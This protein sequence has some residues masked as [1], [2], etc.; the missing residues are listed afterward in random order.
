MAAAVGGRSVGAPGLLRLL[1][2]AHADHGS[3]PWGELFQPAIRLAETGFPL[4][5][6]LHGLLA[7][8]EFLPNMP[9]AAE[10]FY[11]PD[12]TPKPAGTILRNPAFAETLHRIE[13]GG[14]TAFYDGAI[15]RNIVAAVQSYA[16]NP[17]RLTV[18]DLQGYEAK[19]RAVLCRPYRQWEVCAMPPPTSGGVAVLQMLGLLSHFDLAAMAPDSA[20]FVHLFA[21]AGRL[22]YADRDRY[23]ADPDFVPVPVDR[24]LLAPY[25]EERAAL[26]DMDEDMGKAEPG[27]F[28]TQS[29][30]SGSPPDMLP[31]STSHISIVDAAGNAVSFTTSIEMAF[32]SHLMVDGFLLNNQLTDFSFAPMANGLPVANRVQPGKRPRSSMAPVLV[33]E[34]ADG[35][36]GALRLVAGSPGGSQ[37][38]FYVLKTLVA[39]LDW[40]LDPQQAVAMPN[41]ANRNGATEL[42]AGTPLE[43]LR[44][45]LEDMGHEVNPRELVSGL[46]AIL[47]TPDG[48]KGGADPRRPGV[49]LGD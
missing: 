25:L 35:R 31:P 12:G 30:W 9:P 10:Y 16:P 41:L 21:Q 36:R 40:G 34:G 23:L 18:A 11:Q 49:A 45:E 19:R 6:R 46:H 13:S 8:D 32:G 17:G 20:Q 47:L 37:I 44:D 3:L 5:E 15:G 43:G 48:L 7:A 33:F 24:L 2:M 26:I 29:A 27:L 39:V 4:S 22:A 1:E 28:G 38:P 14:A 42:E